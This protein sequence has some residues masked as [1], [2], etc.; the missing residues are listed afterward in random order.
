M[1]APGSVLFCTHDA[2][3]SGALVRWRLLGERQRGETE[4]SCSVL[5]DDQL[6]TADVAAIDAVELRSIAVVTYFGFT[7]RTFPR[8]SEAWSHCF[9]RSVSR[10][11]NRPHP[12]RVDV[13]GVFEPLAREMIGLR[14]GGDERVEVSRAL[15]QQWWIVRAPRRRAPEA[16]SMKIRFDLRNDVRTM[17]SAPHV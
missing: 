9:S 3:R 14:L 1:G 7:G 12:A 15:R 4:L 17:L 6:E 5:V 13:A 10:L 8:H 11:P 16:E 2:A